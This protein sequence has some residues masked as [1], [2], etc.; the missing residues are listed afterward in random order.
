MQDDYFYPAERVQLQ[1]R[2]GEQFAHFDRPLPDIF[3]D[4]DDLNTYL[5]RLPNP[6][7]SSHDE[8]Q[9]PASEELFMSS[10][11]IYEGCM[12]STKYTPTLTQHQQR[13]LR[14]VTPYAVDERDSEETQRSKA[15]T[16]RQLIAGYCKE[17]KR[18]RYARRYRRWQD[19]R[20]R[21]LDLKDETMALIAAEVHDKSLN[22]RFYYSEYDPHEFVGI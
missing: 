18:K 3:A 2:D 1:T 7:D 19:V 22:R 13:L 10:P 11:E 14:D 15:E 4:A 21:G 17:L 8:D 12:T 16:R 9:P 20:S 5:D 6:S